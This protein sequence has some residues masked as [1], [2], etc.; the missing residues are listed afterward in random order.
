M[1]N[2]SGNNPVILTL[3]GH[4]PTG[5]AGVQADMESIH[6]NG[7]RCISVI[8]VLT[9]Q[10]TARFDQIIP[11]D[12]IN[13]RN[14]VE[15][16][17]AD[18]PVN[19]CKIGLI[20]SVE[21]VNVI[22]GLIKTMG[23][24]PLVIDPVLRSG[25]GASLSDT[26]IIDGYLTRLIPL[27]S[28]IT[29]NLAEAHQLSGEKDPAAAAGTLLDTGC[30]NV[31]ITDTKPDTKTVVNILYSPGEKP[32]VIEWERLP[33]VYHGSGCTLSATIAAGLAQGL[34]MRAAVE[35]AQSFTWESLKRGEKLGRGQLHPQ[36]LI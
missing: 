22:A 11:Q 13:F 9:S 4:D 20:G 18:I 23:N 32:G 10:N 19:A 30:L 35:M 36:R 3:S 6:A 1:N 12:P 8:T 28:V 24:I 25:T 16:L 7:G 26:G 14:Q 5:A 27:A 33:G 17:L 2:I 15:L 29:P 21:L 31:L 34:D